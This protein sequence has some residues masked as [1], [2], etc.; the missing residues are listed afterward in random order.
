M[1]CPAGGL[2]GHYTVFLCIDLTPGAY[3]FNT[4]FFFLN[5]S[6]SQTEST[7]LWLLPSKSDILQH[8]YLENLVTCDLWLEYVNI[9]N[10]SV[11]KT[12]P[13]TTKTQIKN[14]QQ[15]LQ[16]S[17]SLKVSDKIW[18]DTVK[19]IKLCTAVNLH[20]LFVWLSPCFALQFLIPEVLGQAV[21]TVCH[22]V[23][24]C[25]EL[26]FSLVRMGFLWDL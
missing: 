15:K 4:D 3:H 11:K 19:K 13:Q 2:A 21:D 17:L 24:E 14:K 9:Q 20:W 6:W 7:F 25:V 10:P 8:L 18:L 22:I 26:L 12:K 1:I 23:L 16:V 5:L